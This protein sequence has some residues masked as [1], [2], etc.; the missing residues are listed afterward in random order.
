MFR[1]RRKR[2]H[3]YLKFQNLLLL[4]KQLKLKGHVPDLLLQV[5]DHIQ[6]IA[7]RRDAEDRRELTRRA[8]KLRSTRKSIIR[9]S[10]RDYMI[11]ILSD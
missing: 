4:N 5:E 3:L 1:M 9:S 11:A 7:V 8:R 6:A 2:N 10:G